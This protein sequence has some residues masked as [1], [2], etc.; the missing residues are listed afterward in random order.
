MVTRYNLMTE[1]KVRDIDDDTFPDPL[2]L[3]YKKIIEEGAFL[4]PFLKVETDDSFIEK[5]YLKVYMYYSTFKGINSMDNAGQVYLD[6]I[7]L[8]LNNIKH[9]DSL[10]GDET[11][12]FPDGSELASF[13]S[14][15]IRE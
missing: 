14:Q 12:Y 13:I 2:S 15:R 7:I 3:N 10:T 11:L 1:S 5:P 8:D 6:D 9:K 4:K